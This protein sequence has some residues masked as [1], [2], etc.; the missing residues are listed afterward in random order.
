[1]SITE[2]RALYNFRACAPEGWLK[3]FALSE[4]QYRNH[5]RG[6]VKLIQ[7]VYVVVF[8]G[9]LSAVSALPVGALAAEPL[10]I[11][12]AWTRSTAPGQRTAGV[13]MQLESAAAAAL[14]AVETPVAAKAELHMMSMEGGV[15]R[16]RPIGKLDLPAKTAV[17]LAPGGLHLMLTEVKRP[18]KTGDTVP[19]TLTIEAAGGTRSTVKVDVEVRAEDGANA[20]QHR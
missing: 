20:H 10:S 17:K 7:I 9:V 5:R 6:F 15:M 8:L 19:L 18:L 2:K 14:V 16:M 1:M 11:K 12:N 3:Q 13:Y 4:A